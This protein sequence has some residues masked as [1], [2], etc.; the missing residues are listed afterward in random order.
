MEAAGLMNDFPCLVIRGI[1][2]Y[3]DSHK[4]K[5]WQPYAA[6]TAAAYAKAILSLV[7]AD[8]VTDTTAAREL[9]KCHISSSLR[10]VSVEKFPDQPQ[11]SEAPKHTLQI[12][13]TQAE[14]IY[15]ILLALQ[16]QLTQL[17]NQLN[18]SQ[19]VS[20]PGSV[21]VSGNDDKTKNNP[22]LKEGIERLQ[23]VVLREGSIYNEEAESFIEDL[24]RILHSVSALPNDCLPTSSNQNT[25]VWCGSK[26]ISPREMKRLCGI[27]NSSHSISLNVGRKLQFYSFIIWVDPNVYPA[28][29]TKVTGEKRIIQKH[30]M[31]EVI[32]QGYKISV[33]LTE[34]SSSNIQDSQSQLALRSGSINTITKVRVRQCS[35]AQTVVMVYIHHVQE[36][37]GFHSLTPII[38]VGK[39]LPNNSA[40]FTIVECGDVDQ[41]KHLLS[42]RQCTLRDR[43]EF[44][45]PLLHVSNS[46]IPYK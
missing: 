43:N 31:K 34:R 27:L 14:D 39:I 2:D 29:K 45:T 10:G 16:G 35:R 4:N 42:K 5:T 25:E 23:N 19:H 13:Q 37:D 40:I 30:K 46:A 3:A 21:H 17:P 9:R 44:G 1:C 7:P 26:D 11:V 18:H 8:D 6:A 15:S 38:S 12:P 33:V 36:L 22:L 24:E 20:L 28:P 41:L 32:I